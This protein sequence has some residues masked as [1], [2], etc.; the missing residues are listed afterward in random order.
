MTAA[1]PKVL[2]PHVMSYCKDLF[3]KFYDVVK[4]ARLKNFTP[5]DKALLK[6]V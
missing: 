2:N 1:M 3:M 6:I 5:F 4:K